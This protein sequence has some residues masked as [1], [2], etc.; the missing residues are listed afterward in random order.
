[1]AITAEAVSFNLLLCL[2]LLELFADAGRNRIIL[3]VFWQN[4]L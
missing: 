3:V 2:I 1:M 4:K